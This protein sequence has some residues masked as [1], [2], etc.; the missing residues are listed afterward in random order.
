MAVVQGAEPAQVIV[1]IAGGDVV[2][3]PEPLLES[4]VICIG[5]LDMDGALEAH[6]RAQGD[7]LVREVR[8]LRKAIGRISIAPQQCVFGQYGLQC[9]GQ[10]GF[11]HLSA[12]RDPVQGLPGTIARHQNAHLL[13]GQARFARFAAAPAG[14]PVQLAA[15]LAG[16][17]KI[18]LVGLR[19][20]LPRSG[21]VCLDAAEEAMPPA[22]RSVAVNL[23]GSGCR[24]KGLGRH[25][26]RAETE[27][28][29]FFA[30]PRQ[31]RA[32]QCVEGAMA[33]LAAN[34]AAVR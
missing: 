17:H 10:L 22:Q 18:R 34:S 21:A 15:A 8:V 13:A 27:P 2:K 24:A 9:A 16:L 30:Q 23:Q 33:R 26:S 4:T 19:D 29:V 1:Q 5:V 11:C 3:A 6:T 28:F 12:S 7:G 25:Q 31:R 32:G 20:A 14:G